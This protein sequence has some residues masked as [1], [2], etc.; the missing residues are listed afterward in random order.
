MVK[1]WKSAP[2]AIRLVFLY[3]LVPAVILGGLFGLLM[4]SLA[5]TEVNGAWHLPMDMLTSAY[6]AMPIS[7]S[8]D[9]T[10]TAMSFLGAFYGWRLLRGSGF[11]RTILQ[12]FS[13]IF[14]VFTLV[15][16]L[17][18]EIQYLELESVPE[19][20]VDV[21]LEAWFIGGLMACIEGAVFFGLRTHSARKYSSVF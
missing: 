16:L 21:G 13:A 11:A 7:T 19:G 10:L 1:N 15:V 12:L 2:W 14:A 8:V 17:Y 9:I 3:R 6:E 4:Y 5:Q 20:L 18:P